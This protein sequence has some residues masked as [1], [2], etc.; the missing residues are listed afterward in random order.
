M[1]SSSHGFLIRFKGP[2]GLICVAEFWRNRDLGRGRGQG[3][4]SPPG[5]ARSGLATWCF[6]ALARE[7]L[8][9][10]EHLRNSMTAAGLLLLITFDMVFFFYAFCRA[11]FLVPWMQHVPVLFCRSRWAAG[12]MTG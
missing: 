7:A 8:Q 11:D 12:G 10:K 4:V 5:L 6:N 3:G 1:H 9:W 2:S